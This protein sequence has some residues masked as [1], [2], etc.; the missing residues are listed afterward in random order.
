MRQKTRQL[1]LAWGRA[2]RK[3]TPPPQPVKRA[4]IG[5]PDGGKRQLGIP[6]VVDRLIQQM[7]LQVLEPLYDPAFSP[8]SYGFRPGK[9]AHQ[10][11]TQAKSHVEAGYGW[12]VDLD[13]EKFFDRVNHDLLMGR[14]AK[15]IGDK[16][17][18]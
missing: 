4:E 11:L 5:K 16:R 14:L 13:L 8:N 2:H 1:V 10:A 12:V 15:R 9:S 18:L 17:V 7:L 3:G 6:A